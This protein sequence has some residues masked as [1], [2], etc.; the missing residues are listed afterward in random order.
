MYI[1]IVKAHTQ[2]DNRL[3]LGN[4]TNIVADWGKFQKAANNIGIEY[5]TFH[6]Y[7]SLND[8]NEST[9]IELNDKPNG[10]FSFPNL[11]IIENN[12]STDYS[13]C[14]FLDEFKTFMR[15]EV[16]SLA[17]VYVFKDGRESPA[18]HI[19][20]RE[21]ITATNP[22]TIDGFTYDLAMAIQE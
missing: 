17:I 21:A 5:F 19:P 8:C 10:T 4:L 20:G 18:F 16:Y 22:V 2:I 11:N 14:L 13:D 15:D 12:V 9:T 7:E 3:I 1:D 6:K